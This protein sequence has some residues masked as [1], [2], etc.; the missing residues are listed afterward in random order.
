MGYVSAYMN[1]FNH[2]SSAHIKLLPGDL[3]GG[4]MYFNAG[5]RPLAFKADK[6]M[7]SIEDDEFECLIKK[8]TEDGRNAKYCNVYTFHGAVWGEFKAF[9]DRNHYLYM[10]DYGSV[11]RAFQMSVAVNWMAHKRQ[12]QDPK[13][14]RA[15]AAHYIGE[16]VAARCCDTPCKDFGLG[17]Y[18]MGARAISLNDGKLSDDYDESWIKN[19]LGPYKNA[20]DADVI[21]WIG[22][23][24]Y[25]AAMVACD[26]SLRPDESKPMMDVYPQKYSS[27]TVKCWNS[28]MDGIPAALVGPNMGAM[29]KALSRLIIQAPIEAKKISAEK[30]RK[31]IERMEANA[32]AI[33]STGRKMSAS[34][35]IKLKIINGR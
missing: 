25:E 4:G 12:R 2:M 3:G 32:V 33:T 30:R 8:M 23:V 17:L 20:K 24:L 21:K 6:K 14:I 1:P 16:C 26:M 27:E 10:Y 22:L 35:I 34:D 19:I 5:P 9:L 7:S 13:W 18:K 29:R 11:S 31:A 28:L 15:M